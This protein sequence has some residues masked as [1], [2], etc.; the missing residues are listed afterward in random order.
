M[1]G[2]KGISS[3][4]AVRGGR[5][6]NKKMNLLYIGVKDYLQ[7]TIVSTMYQYF[8]KNNPSIALIPITQPEYDT[9]RTTTATNNVNNCYTQSTKDQTTNQNYLRRKNYSKSMS[10]NNSSNNDQTSQYNQTHLEPKMNNNLTNTPQLE[11]FTKTL[12]PN[13]YLQKNQTSQSEGEQ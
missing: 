5:H 10:D 4:N 12:V 13:G 1:K 11:A 9:Q 3:N 6:D 2:T 8:M 7:T